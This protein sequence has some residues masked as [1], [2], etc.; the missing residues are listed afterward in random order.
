MAYE[1]H[2]DLTQVAVA[3]HQHLQVFADGH[4]ER[5]EA[6]QGELDRALALTQRTVAEARRVIE[7]LR[8]TALDD[9]GLATALWMHTEELRARGWEIDYEEDLGEERPSPEVETALYRVPQEALTNVG[10]HAQTKRARVTLT[11]L[12]RNMPFSPRRGEA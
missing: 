10:K 6:G 11:R 1:V 12:P 7:G 5:A 4:S 9:F 8:P 2:D 3:A